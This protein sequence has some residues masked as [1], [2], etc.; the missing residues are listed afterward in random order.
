MHIRIETS[1]S[2]SSYYSHCPL[3]ASHRR[4]KKVL[5]TAK[6]SISC[7]SGPTNKSLPT[8]HHIDIWGVSQRQE[9]PS[10]FPPL[11]TRCIFIVLYVFVSPYALAVFTHHME[12]YTSLHETAP[13]FA[14]P[15]QNASA[16]HRVLRRSYS[17]ASGKVCHQNKATCFF[18]TIHEPAGL[19]FLTC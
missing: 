11:L 16:S 9:N 14:L 17:F 10:S 3:Y 1:V 6:E 2:P 12:S 5:G 13:R 4:V 7:V 15:L 18:P 8:G 19:F